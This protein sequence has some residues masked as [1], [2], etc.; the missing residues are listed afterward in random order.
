MTTDTAPTIDLHDPASYKSWQEE[1]VRFG[2][3][4]VLGHVNNL[5]MGSYFENARV[6]LHRQVFPNWPQVSHLFVLAHTSFDYY[7]ELLYPAQLRIGTRVLKFGRS[8]MHTGA[9]LFHEEKVIAQSQTV[10]VLIDNK[11]RKPVEIPAALRAA[12]IGIAG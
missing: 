12:F 6:A 4:D 1:H 9:A 7:H 8:S 5:A 11:T 3:L 10:S 2:D